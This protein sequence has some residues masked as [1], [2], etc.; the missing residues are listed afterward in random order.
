[1]VTWLVLFAVLGTFLAL[2]KGYLS[3]FGQSSV[4]SIEQDA[5]LTTGA[6]SVPGADDGQLALPVLAAP[7]SP[8]TERS[9]PPA[10][11]DTRPAAE[12]ALEMNA[13]SPVQSNPIGAG[14]LLPVPP[15][16]AVDE[17]QM[18]AETASLALQAATAVGNLTEPPLKPPSMAQQGI[19]LQF[20]GPCWVDVRDAKRK[21]KL[22]GEMPKGTRKLLGGTPPYDV[23]L[24][25]ASVVKVSVN[26]VSYDVMRHARG[27]VAR[28]KLDPASS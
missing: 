4:T 14:S 10:R 28:F 8:S 13:P 2:W 24:G 20:D 12:R 27:N 11:L 18:P 22:F 16:R 17:P 21:F 23:V 25:N 6:L 15:A 19:V 5:E 7:D 26:G 1:L 3:W 9:N